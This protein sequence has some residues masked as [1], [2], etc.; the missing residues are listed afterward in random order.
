MQIYNRLVAGY[1][2]ILFFARK[3][4]IHFIK[5][6]FKKE[7]MDMVVGYHS[8]Q[9]FYIRSKKNSYKKLLKRYANKKVSDVFLRKFC[10]FSRNN[11]KIWGK[12]KFW[13]FWLGM[14]ILYYHEK[15]S[16]S[17]VML[18]WA[19]LVGYVV[20]FYGCFVYH[21][22]KIRKIQAVVNKVTAAS[23]IKTSIT[24]IL[25][26]RMRKKYRAILCLYIIIKISQLEKKIT[27]ELAALLTLIERKYFFKI[28]NEYMEK[29]LLILLQQKNDI[30]PTIFLQYFTPSIPIPNI[31]KKYYQETLE[32]Y[33]ALKNS[34]LSTGSLKRASIIDLP[35]AHHCYFESEARVQKKCFNITRIQS[36]KIFLTQHHLQI[37]TTY[38]KMFHYQTIKR[39]EIHY[40]SNTIYIFS[41]KKVCVVVTPNAPNFFRMC[42]ALLMA[43]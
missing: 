21:W 40:P 18:W 26:K 29:A 10:S 5:E 33:K 34:R 36:G 28:V 22:W 4:Y 42:C 43:Q 24:E 3:L 12:K 6:P 37:V 8:T 16:E 31:N 17:T 30:T 15:S 14:L 41:K 2:S 38:T 27:N 13:A 35:E 20:F 7:T 1:K 19:A 11:Y 32:Q 9:G 39:L 25:P 23:N